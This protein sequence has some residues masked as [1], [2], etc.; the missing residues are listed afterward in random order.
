MKHLRL[1]AA[2]CLTALLL[3]CAFTRLHAQGTEELLTT[4]G[5]TVERDGRFHAYILWQ[6]G[7]AAATLGKRFAVHSKAG[8]ADAPGPYQRLGIQTLQSSANTCRALLE[9]GATVDMAAA[10][11]PARIDGLY[12]D[13]TL[14]SDGPPAAPA[15]PNLDAAGKLAYLIQS[16]VSDE[17]T[18]SNLYFLG[19]AHPAVMMALGHAFAIPVKPGIHTFEVR[20]V[21]SAD[22][23]VRVVGR[24]TLDTSAPV[25][26]AA[27]ASPFQV[28]HPVNPADQHTVS[29]KDHLNARL[30]WGVGP[31]LRAQI[32][33]TFGFDVFRVQQKTAEILGWHTTPP[34][35]EEITTAL[36]ANDPTDPNPTIARS[37]ELPVLVGDLLTPAE[38][39]DASNRERFDFSDDGVWH[40]G[41]DGTPVRRPYSDG[42][43]FYFFVAARTITG[44]PGTLS[45][46]TLV[47]MCDALP[48]LPPV[49]D[50]VLSQ[51]TPPTTPAGWAA[52]GG[53]QF[54]QV[55]IRQLPNAPRE[56]TAS[57]YYI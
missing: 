33:H 45:T 52:Q 8:A 34:S 32:P 49:I 25:I 41:S 3:V 18:L 16:A 43:A 51:F 20:E 15:D 55:K 14:R 17:R 53:S 57:G 27:P 44:A 36:A 28:L 11:A 42:E 23:D 21:D 46:G 48:P 56:E 24:V 38:A 12:R 35:P 9:V 10:S 39:G 37:N 19:R 13:V 26:P 4:V 40:R 22:A 47:V 50:S 1:S 30:R 31:A 54:L 7:D 6:P 5:T 2:R 29:P